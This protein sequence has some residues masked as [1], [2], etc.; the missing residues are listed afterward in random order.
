MENENKYRLWVFTWNASD[1]PFN[2]LGYVLPD[3]KVLK[4]FLEFYCDDY[5][6]QEEVGENTNRHHLQGAFKLKN[7][8]RFTTLI[9]LFKE[10]FIIID[11]VD[12]TNNL[13]LDRMQGTWTEAS[14]YCVKRDT[15]VGD[16]ISSQPLQLYGGADVSFLEDKQKRYPWQ[17]R[18]FN[19]I[20]ESDSL[21][22]KD[23]DDRE[24]IW[25]FDPIGNS[26]KS[27]FVKYLCSAS[28]N[29]VKI[30]FGTAPQLRSAIISIGMRKVYIIDMPRTLSEEDSL[31][32]LISTL[33]DLKNGFIVSVFYGKYQKLLMDP[34]VV[35]V[36]SNKICPMRMMSDDRWLNLEINKKTM[37]L[38]ERYDFV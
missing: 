6:F 16:V 11:D 10:T 12:L 3:K 13:T 21:S 30:T 2:E 22:I 8:M 33:E 20:F 31:P 37:D 35:I 18:L 34:P 32:S 15:R 5:V 24:I 29:V 14:N 26:G 38:E 1:Y 4:D 27:K 17:N 23:P 28:N 19:K 9:K 25:I 7:R 36:F